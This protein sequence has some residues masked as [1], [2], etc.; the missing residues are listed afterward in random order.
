MDP[1]AATTNRCGDCCASRS[2]RRR[3]S[4]RPRPRRRRGNWPTRRPCSPNWPDPTLVPTRC[5]A[6]RSPNSCAAGGRRTGYR[7]AG[8]AAAGEVDRGRGF[9]RRLRRQRRHRRRGAIGA[10]DG[11]LTRRDRVHRGA[12]GHDGPGPADWPRSHRTEHR[13]ARCADPGL[14]DI[15]ALLLA[16]PGMGRRAAAAAWS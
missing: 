2:A 3:W 1:N 6:R 14:A 5:S 8:G 4:S 7:H 15:A 10:S 16:V 9:R 11:R 12:R 13:A